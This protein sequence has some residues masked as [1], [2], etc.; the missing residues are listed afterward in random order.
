MIHLL[1]PDPRLLTAGPL[2]CWLVGADLRHVAVHGVEVVQRIYA[3]VRDGQWGTLANRI[4]AQDI[5]TSAHGFCVHTEVLAEG[6]GINYRA[7][8]THTGEADG[9]L[10][11]A[12]DGEAHSSFASMRL[13]LCVHHPQS[14]AGTR[15]R[16]GH[17]DGTTEEVLLPVALAPW[18]PVQ[19][20]RSLETTLLEAQI[21]L[22]F[23]GTV[24]EMEDQ[25]NYGDASFKT[26]C[27]P[28]AWPKPVSVAPGDR[29]AHRLTVQVIKSPTKPPPP[30]SS[31]TR[32]QVSDQRRTRARI[33]HLELSKTGHVML[34]VD[35]TGSWKERVAAA[36]FQRSRDGLP[37]VLWVAAESITRARATALAATLP[38]DSELLVLDGAGGSDCTA[39]LALLRTAVALEIPVGAGTRQ[40]FS[41]INRGVRNVGDLLAFSINPVVHADDDWS[42]LENTAAYATIVSSAR[43]WGKP[44][45]IGP[46]ALPL[47]DPRRSSEKGATWLIAALAHLLPG[48]NDLDAVTLASVTDLDGTPS[49]T[50]VTALAGT[51]DLLEVSAHAG[52]VIA[53]AAKTAAGTR[54]FIANTGH[55]PAAVL[56]SGLRQGSEAL[57]LAPWGMT[58]LDG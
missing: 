52:R 45:R 42:V 21:R 56:V 16:V 55:L 6:E 13:G 4:I 20:I 43:A 22:T 15:T 37:V 28:Q 8:F 36:E 2:T 31:V 48:M 46:L 47:H 40:Q 53:F 29:V 41:E 7:T 49:G 44:L 54:V 14:L 10:S 58:I 39:A 12:Y 57:R 3:V 1:G 50:V 11:V 26:Y 33:G 32:I 27:T 9:T 38:P 5:T 30:P 35:L 17:S 34:P 18:E 25:R 24:F 19:D 51:T 23:S